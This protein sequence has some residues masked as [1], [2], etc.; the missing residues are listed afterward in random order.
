MSLDQGEL[1]RNAFLTAAEGVAAQRPEVDLAFAR[2]ALE[3]AAT[4][5]HNG[6]ALDH[7]DEHDFAIVVTGL[8]EDLVSED[9]GAALRARAERALQD[10]EGLHDP[11]GV[12]GAYL[13]SATILKL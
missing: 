5:L 8:C 11:D 7:L 9:Q 6:L 3:E 13:V 12:S 2:E 10:P 4:Y 1:L